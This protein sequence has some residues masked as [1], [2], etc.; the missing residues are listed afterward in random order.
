MDSYKK[1]DKSEPTIEYSCTLKFSFQY[2]SG[3]F[4]AVQVQLQEN[5][6][7]SLERILANTKRYHTANMKTKP[8]YGQSKMSFYTRDKK[9]SC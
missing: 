7:I 3:M 8:E 4:I 9:N 1:V 2:K 5:K 6:G